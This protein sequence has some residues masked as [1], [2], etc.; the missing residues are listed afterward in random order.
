MLGLIH[1]TPE[2]FS[3]N[4]SFTLILHPHYAVACEQA[5]SEVGKNARPARPK[6]HSATSP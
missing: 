2:E 6:L 4:G 5:P 1:N 3:R